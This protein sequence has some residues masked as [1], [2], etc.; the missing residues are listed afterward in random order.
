MRGVP[1][2]LTQEA[3]CFFFGT[4]YDFVLLRIAW[5]TE[6]IVLDTLVL[7]FVSFYSN[8]VSFASGC[9]IEELIC[10]EIT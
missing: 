1:Y 3:S 8:L 7:V 9:D 10:S 4:V 2:P 5:E 6:S